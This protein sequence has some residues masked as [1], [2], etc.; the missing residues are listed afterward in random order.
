MSADD[1]SPTSLSLDEPTL[2]GKITLVS[3]DGQTFLADKQHA[4]VSELIRNALEGD[5]NANQVPLQVG[6]AALGKV[7]AYLQHHHG[8]EPAAIA[9]PLSSADL[10]T[11]TNDVDAKFIAEC[12]AEHLVFDVIQ[13]ANYMLIPRLSDLGV[14][15]V[16]SLLKASLLK[17]EPLHEMANELASLAGRA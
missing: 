3:Q 7:V 1:P 12:A 9:A 16:A 13:A 5:E 8:L 6:A 10:G 11:L 4:C 15:K 14:A 2:Q 17:D